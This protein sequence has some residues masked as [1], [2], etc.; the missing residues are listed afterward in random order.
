ME[1]HGHHPQV[2]FGLKCLL[3]CKINEKVGVHL[4]V[5]KFCKSEKAGLSG[6]AFWNIR[7]WQFQNRN[8]T[9]VKHED[10]KV[11]GCFEAWKMT[12]WYQGARIEEI[13]VKS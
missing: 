7:F 8:M 3:M 12:N 2:K 5:T 4:L 11:Q 10:L 13:Q 9:G 6:F 1:H